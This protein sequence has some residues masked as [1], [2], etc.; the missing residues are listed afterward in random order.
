MV[1]RTPTI[2][3]AR[4]NFAAALTEFTGP[5]DEEDGLGPIFNAE[6]CGS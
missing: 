5:E 6:G 4:C 1:Q 3:F 2:P